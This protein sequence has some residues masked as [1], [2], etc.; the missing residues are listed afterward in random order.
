M[1]N[2]LCDCTTTVLSAIPASDCNQSVGYIKKWLFQ[3][4]GTTNIFDGSDSPATNAI[5]AFASWQTFLAASDASKIV[6][7]KRKCSDTVIPMS[8]SETEDSDA[9]TL[10]LREN[11]V[12]VTS[13]YRNLS[14]AEISAIKA[15]GCFNS[16]AVYG[17]NENNQIVAWRNS[18][19]IYT[20]IPIE[21]RTFSL[22]SP[23][24]TGNDDKSTLKF[25]LPSNWRENARI[26]TTE[27][28][29]LVQLT[30]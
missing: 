10:I 18:S 7:T 5:E 13:I 25:T 14:E 17:V 28:N 24:I 19:E 4:Q 11:N 30:P 8:E 3:I 15:I 27:F 16:I 2:L 20:G 9:N 22:T 1:P 26:I 23:E 29:P 21:D 6:T 12:P